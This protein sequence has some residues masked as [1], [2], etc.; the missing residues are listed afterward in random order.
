MGD[1]I[2]VLQS[3]A[4]QGHGASKGMLNCCYDHEAGAHKSSKDEL[5]SNHKAAAQGSPH[6]Q[7]SPPA[8]TIKGAVRHEAQLN[9]ASPLVPKSGQ[10]RRCPRTVC[11]WD[12]L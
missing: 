1:V 3:A 10:A 8:A 5:S 6:A 7:F 11:P 9:E 2:G 12:L 4:D